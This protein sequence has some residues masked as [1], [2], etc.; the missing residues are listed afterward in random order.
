M[1]ITMRVQERIQQINIEN[2]SL[3]EVLRSR[4]YLSIPAKQSMFDKI[5]RNENELVNLEADLDNGIEFIDYIP[6]Y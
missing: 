4:T 3:Y 6:K 5:K 1:V 2:R